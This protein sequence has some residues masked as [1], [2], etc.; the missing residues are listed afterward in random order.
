MIRRLDSSLI[1]IRVE[2]AC[3]SV[4]RSFFGWGPKGELDAPI[5]AESGIVNLLMTLKLIR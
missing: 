5:A 1:A 4:T 2:L 3:R